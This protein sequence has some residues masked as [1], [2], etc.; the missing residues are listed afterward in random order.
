MVTAQEVIGLDST[1]STYKSH[2]WQKRFPGREVFEKYLLS[3]WILTPGHTH[4]YH[5]ALGHPHHR[6]LLLALELC[7]L[8]FL[9][10]DYSKSNLVAT[11]LFG[12]GA[13]AVI[14]EGDEVARNSKSNVQL[15]ITGSKS[16][17]Y[18][19]SLDVM[20]WHVVDKGLQVMFAQRIPQIVRENSSDDM[21]EFLKDYGLKIGD[22]SYYLLHPG[23][24]KVLK[25]YQLALGLD[26][27][28]LSFSREVIREYGNMSSVTVLFVLE[29]FLA[30]RK[31]KAGENIIV[32]A[33]GPGFSSE[34]LLLK[35]IEN[36]KN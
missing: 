4:A 23:G 20:G 8:T 34:T 36:S 12:D 25:A 29:K 15:R 27:D 35:G 1:Y 16:K 9:A 10:D 24:T 6:V 14:I 30:S 28:G 21:A 31:P 32:S 33:L 18:P 3:D 11:A 22:I 17:L 26:D 13:A 7:S 19:D 5:Y 2:F